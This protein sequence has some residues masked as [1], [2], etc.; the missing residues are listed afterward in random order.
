MMFPVF[1]L[2]AFG[3]LA[4]LGMLVFWA[5]IVVLV[6]WAVRSFASRPVAA[7]P[8]PLEI[9]NA[10]LARGEISVEEYEKVKQ[11]LGA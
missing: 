11:T 8:T 9:L 3:L 6:V 10:R 5:G 1:P 4:G 7:P 2:H